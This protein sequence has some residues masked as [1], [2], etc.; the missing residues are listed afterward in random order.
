MDDFVYGPSLDMTGLMV[1]GEKVLFAERSRNFLQ[2][3]IMNQEGSCPFLYAWHPET[4][5]WMWYGKVIHNAKSKA[6]EMTQEIPLTSFANRFRLSEEELELSHIDYVAL[7]L[8]LQDGT[9]HVLKPNNPS[10]SEA[11]EKYVRI[12]AGSFVEFEFTPPA[13]VDAGA[14]KRSTLTVRGYYEPYS[15]L[16][17]GDNADKPSVVP[18]DFR[19]R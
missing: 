17:V 13:D 11:D 5:S 9:S 6:R 3:T 4:Q 18:I 1:N 14:V 2:A 19:N 16:N 7:T 10:L 15:S 12:P 8:E